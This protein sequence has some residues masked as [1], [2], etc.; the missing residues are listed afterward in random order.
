MSLFLASLVMLG[1]VFVFTNWMVRRLSEQVSAASELLARLCAQA[2][3]PA[4]RDPQLRAILSGVIAGTDFPLVIADERGIPRAWRLVGLDPA[5]VPDASLDSLAAGR[6]IAPVI[7]AR[8]NRLYAKIEEL[9]R[10]HP[11]ILMTQPLTRAALGRFH[12]G[13]PPLLER[14]RWMP[15]VTVGGL[16]ALIGLGLWGLETVRRN[17]RRNIWVGM[18]LETAHQLGTPLSSLMG[19]VE[20]LRERMRESPSEPVPRADL[21]ETLEEME[22]DVDRL[23]K[24]AQRFSHV[25]S[26]PRLEALDVSALVQRVVEYMRRRV[27]RDEGDVTLSERIEKTTPLPC[28]RELL[29]WAIENLI[30]NALNALDK[31]PGRIEVT[32]AP[33]EA[34]GVEITV[35][36]NGRGMSAVEQRRAFEPGYT[37][38]PRGWGLGLALARRVVEEYHRGRLSVRKSVPGEGTTIAIVL[39]G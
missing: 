21:V 16:V 32:V 4:A 15:Y 11:A 30:G 20:L 7:R 17:E 24:V 33:R 39:P 28:S 1:S 19:W 13:D 14:L 29:E 23:N 6:P 5:L 8:I 12:Y 9:D 36:D 31:R 22:R 18:A 2:S 37:T 3:F 10:K 35:R 27:P 26:A 25:G 38:K 34:G